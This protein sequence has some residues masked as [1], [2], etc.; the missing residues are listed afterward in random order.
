MTRHSAS[1]SPRPVDSDEDCYVI[2]EVPAPEPP[3]QG[4][5]VDVDALREKLLQLVANAPL[6]EA[7][8]TVPLE[9]DIDW[10]DD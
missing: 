4:E 7:R 5:A 8:W 2:D 3:H 1:L 10:A 9:L 6:I